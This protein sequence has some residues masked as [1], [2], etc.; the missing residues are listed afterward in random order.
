[1]MKPQRFF[2]DFSGK[3]E[4]WISSRILS[5]KTSRLAFATFLFVVPLVAFSLV[6]YIRYGFGLFLG[7]DT[8]T[9]VWSAKLF[10]QEGLQYSVSISYPNLYI[11]FLAGF[12]LLIGSASLAEKIFPFLVAAPLGYAYYWLTRE[13]TNDKRLGYLGALLGGLMLN[14]IRLES[15]LH[16]NL[17]S[18]STSMILGAVVA[19]QLRQPFSW[20]TQW[21]RSLLVWLPLVAIVAYTQ[22]ETY[23][24]LS[25]SLLLMF[26]FTRKMKTTFLALFVFALPVLIA[27]PLIWRFLLNYGAGISL[28]ALFPQSLLSILADSF[29]FLG[30][31]ALP[32][33]ALGLVDIYRN[34][35]R[36]SQAALFVISWLIVLVALLPFAT[37]LGLP[38]DRFLYVVPIPVIV[39]S[40][41]KSTFRAGSAL[42]RRGWLPGS[43]PRVAPRIVRR[44]A[45]PAVVAL[46]LIA[47]LATSATADAFL[48][49]YVSQDDSNRLIQAANLVRKAGYNQ[50]IL[51]MYGR[52]AADVNPIYK[53]YFGI[54]I[55]NRLA[56]YGKLQYLFT[57]PDPG[58]VYDWQYNPPFEQTS[59][60]QTRTDILN[61]LGAPSEVALHPLVIAGGNTYDRPLSEIFLSQFESA[62]GSG[63]YVIPPGLLTADQIDYWR[64]FAYSDW[65][66][67]TGASIVS[68]PW[69]K[70]HKVLDY[71]SAGSQALFDANYTISLAKSWGNMTLALRL[72]D[73]QPA[74]TFPDTSSAVLAP[75]G[76]FFDNRLVLSHT[77]GGIQGPLD[78]NIPLGNVASG[79]HT[80]RV[81]SSSTSSGTGVAVAIDEIQV[82]PVQCSS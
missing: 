2:P 22:I 11:I 59:S 46:L 51:V 5:T 48:R 62:P 78:I 9:Y 24:V 35:R 15:D 73:W 39:A 13:I 34:A 8:S 77:Y 26:S 58:K 54:E 71:L 68:V 50:P 19:Y 53:A 33:T 45:A 49:P 65:T 70:A 56:Y 12:G 42:A 10:Y 25:L 64:L 43:L 4:T 55:P 36:G 61:Q 28:A 75:L 52:T 27:L 20:R 76:I 38:F 74:Y 1:M 82:C 30:G 3:F 18:F 40:G 37:I 32:W 29:L 81:R 80:I 14:T 66:G 7:W 47:V 44:S 6:Q 60:L 16:R 21:K 31:F 17:L 57:L 67:T 72:Y 63:I 41:V 79:L 69:A 23:V